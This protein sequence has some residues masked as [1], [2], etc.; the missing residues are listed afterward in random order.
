[1]P[2]KLEYNLDISSVSRWNMMS[3][4]ANA[5]A[6]LIYAQEIGDFRAGKDYFTRRYSFNSFLV[7]LTIAGCGQLDYNGQQHLLTPGQFFWIDCSKPQ[8][9][10]T[11]PGHD[12][13]HIVW[14][15]FYGGNARSYYDAFLARNKGAPVGTFP[16]HPKALD[17][18]SSLLELDPNSPDQMLVDFRASELLT[19]LVTECVMSTMSVDITTNMPQI[20]QDVR[21]YLQNTYTQKHTLEALGSQFNINPQYLQKQF[22]RYMSMSPSEYLIFLRMTRAKELL[23]SSKLSIGDIALSVGID[24]LGYFTRRFKTQEG[25]TPQA[26]RRLWP[27]PEGVSPD[28]FREIPP[29][30]INRE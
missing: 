7:K 14:V 29:E 16:N 10:R 2:V 26:Y 9:Y 3:P 22:K 15:H 27:G 4:T 21:V 17:I 8:H 11:A 30:E 5:K 28:R 23:R 12:N 1:M 25:M 20:I 18:F 13:W 24:N 19:Q 6:S